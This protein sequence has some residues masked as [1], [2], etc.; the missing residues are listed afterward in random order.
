MTSLGRREGAYRRRGRR[1]APTA[2]GR[3]RR[4]IAARTSSGCLQNAIART[5]VAGA[6][7]TRQPLRWQLVLPKQRHAVGD[8]VRKPGPAIVL[9]LIWF[10]VPASHSFGPG[11]RHTAAEAPFLLAARA[12]LVDLRRPCTA[13]FCAARRTG[14]CTATA[15]LGA[16]QVSCFSRN[17]LNDL[18]NL[19]SPPPI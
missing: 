14:C 17:C 16:R 2:A 18:K 8:G 13:D 11:P 9:K 7:H 19:K 10:L 6:L 5:V 1:R 15:V 3:A 4:G 12:G